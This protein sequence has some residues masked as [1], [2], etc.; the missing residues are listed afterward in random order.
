MGDLFIPQPSDVPDMKNAMGQDSGSR[1]HHQSDPMM[2]FVL[3]K[4]I[5]KFGNVVFFR[6]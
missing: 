5:Q 1:K 3:C 6:S 4:P 2:S